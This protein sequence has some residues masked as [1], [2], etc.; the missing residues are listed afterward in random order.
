MTTERCMTQSEL[1]E[2][3]W[4]SEATLE[5]W[6]TEAGGPLVATQTSLR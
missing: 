3:W 5:R 6:R 2:Q 1:A 4:I